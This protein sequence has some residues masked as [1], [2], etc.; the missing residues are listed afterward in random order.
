MTLPAFDLT[1]RQHILL[2]SDLVSGT[3]LLL[4]L[5]SLHG[6]G[7]LSVCQEL[8]LSPPSVDLPCVLGVS[9]RGPGW[10]LDGPEAAVLRGAL[11][12]G[13][14]S[15]CLVTSG[16]KRPTIPVLGAAMVPFIFKK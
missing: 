16:P 14:C 6:H 4:D 7:R 9:G 2:T 13:L 12:R 1:L 5:S 3:Q 15:E 11:A 8:P 10:A